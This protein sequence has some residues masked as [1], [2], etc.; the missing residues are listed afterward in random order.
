MDVP[1]PQAGTVAE[2]QVKVGDRVS[3]GSVM[4]TLEAEGAAGTPPKEK[5]KGAGPPRAEPAGYG[6]PA[7]SYETIEVRVPDIGDF[8][9]V[10]G[11]R[12]ARRRVR[13]SR[14]TTR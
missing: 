12:G 4:L 14:P 2:L 11:D 3:E 9:D 7:G 10:A 5:V 13:R 6:S 1:A 8:K